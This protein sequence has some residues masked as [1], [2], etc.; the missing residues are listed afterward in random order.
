MRTVLTVISALFLIGCVATSENTDDAALIKVGMTNK[1]VKSILGPPGNYQSKNEQS[2]WQYCQTN[3]F[4]PVNDLILIYFYN[5][6]V[7]AVQTYY[8]AGF[9]ACSALFKSIDWNDAPKSPNKQ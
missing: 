7:T 9:G 3:R 1:E 6:K 4:S 5:R 8:N 2:A